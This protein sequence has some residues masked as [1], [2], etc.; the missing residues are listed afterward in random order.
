MKKKLKQINEGFIRGGAG[1]IN[2]DDVKKVLGKEDDIMGKFTGLLDKFFED[3]KLFYMLL[4]DYWNGRYRDIPWWV[5]A[6]IAFA[7]LYVLN[8]FDLIPDAIPL[9][10]QIDDVAVMVLCLKMID[11]EVQKYK[12]WKAMDEKTI[13]VKAEKA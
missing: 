3:V 13:D 2:E 11:S 10:G 12:K 1:K 6:A 7:L 5:I 4:K 9:L 8:P